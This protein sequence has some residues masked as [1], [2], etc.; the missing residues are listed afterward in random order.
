MY[1]R[2]TN[3]PGTA[4]VLSFVFNG[5]GQIYNGQIKKG[6]WLVAISSLALLAVIISGVFIC[7]WL[8]GRVMFPGQLVGSLSVFILAVLFIA[9]VGI[10]S[11]F[12]A[13]KSACRK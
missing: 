6:L 2:R 1:T 3:H 8:L 11:I 4:A 13:Y 7:C 10:Y 12:D 5:L 9:F